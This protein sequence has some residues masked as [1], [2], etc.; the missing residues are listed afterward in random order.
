MIPLNQ[1]KH[2]ENN[3]RKVSASKEGVKSLAASI[4]SQGV[5]HNLVVRPNGSGYIVVDGNRR[6][7][8]LKHL[9]GDSSANEVPCVIMNDVNETEVGL[10]ANMMR[11]NMHPL[12]E[13]DAIYALVSD[14]EED[15]D[16]VGK[17]F[18][19][20]TK[21]VKQRISLAE[22]SD[23]AKEMFRNYDFGIGVAMALTLGDKDK[24]D[25]FLEAYSGQK[26]SASWVKNSMVGGK[27]S[28]DRALFDLSDPTPQEVSDLGI[29]SD[30][31]SDERY[32]TNIDVFESYQEHHIHKMIQDFRDEGY[33][34]VVY[35][36]DE[37]W[38]DSPATRGFKLVQE[39]NEDLY[40]CEDLI[41][42][43]SYNTHSHSL[44]TVKMVPV[45]LEEQTE[46]DASEQPEE[47]VELTPMLM[48]KPQQDLL[49]GY[50]GAFVKDSMWDNYQHHMIKFMKALL[51]HRRLGYTYSTINRVGNVYA[52]YQNMFPPQEEPDGYTNPNYENYINEHIQACQLAYDNN[53][54]AP[55]DYCL[56]LTNEELDK[57]FCAICLTSLSKHDMLNE[58]VKRNIPDFTTG[59]GW[60]KPD[61]KWLNKY[62]IEQISMLEDYVFGKVSTGT[63]K[64]RVQALSDHLSS[65][66][67]FD[68][69][70]SW[71]QLK[72]QPEVDAFGD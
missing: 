1:L 12:D 13:C 59:G 16:S 33:M 35:L 50:H 69:F 65:D 45:E 41:M 66:P 18:G 39:H 31:F 46:L 38:F 32:I 23:K 37:Y 70:G 44:S 9:Y 57:L 56:D 62:K 49:K 28:V 20:T 26:L 63:K 24:Q 52:D 19:Q 43:V 48:S 22:L 30:L 2:T 53:G 40:S 15:F 5:L 4:D 42:L 72:P 34:D 64:E 3:V 51:C 61:T 60:F 47:E 55:L 21:W 58:V 27:I 54:T 25:K 14:G 6:L 11:E 10:H 67:V 7:E 8:A 29:E 36:K 17:R 71:P 68:P